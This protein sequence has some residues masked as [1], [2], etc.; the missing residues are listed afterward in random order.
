MIS[1]T[2]RATSVAPV[3]VTDKVSVVSITTLLPE[4]NSSELLPGI[5]VEVIS[6]TSWLDSLLAPALL[7]VSDPRVTVALTELLVVLP[8]IS[9]SITVVAV[10][11]THLTL[12]TNREV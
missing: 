1:I 10:S 6:S 12:P 9:P 7:P 11:Y 4:S 2:D 5:G 8:I 3:P